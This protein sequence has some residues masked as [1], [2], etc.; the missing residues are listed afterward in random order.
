MEFK[1][2][3]GDSELV[4]FS[5]LKSWVLVR[6]SK[7]VRRWEDQRIQIFKGLVRGRLGNDQKN[8][9]RKRKIS[10]K[11]EESISFE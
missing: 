3:A 1:L 4:F 2:G 8:E 10:Q 6:S 11:P 7:G 9:N 5:I